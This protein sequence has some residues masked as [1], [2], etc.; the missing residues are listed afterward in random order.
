MA[1]AETAKDLPQWLPLADYVSA[2]P[3]STVLVFRDGALNRSNKL[4]AALRSKAEVWQFPLRKGP[5]LYSWIQ[6]RV[7]KSGGTISP[8]AVRLLADLVGGDL[9]AGNSEIEKL[10]LYASG[11][12]I[13]DNDVRLLVSHAQESNI[14]AMVDAIIARR[15]SAA[16]LLL[17]RLM[18][19]GAAPAYILTMITRQFRMLAQATELAGQELSQAELGRQ[20][21]TTS[22]FALRKT[23][24]QARGY[25]LAQLV[26]VYRRLLDADL[27]IKTG[28]WG[29][30]MALD[31]LITNLCSS[32]GR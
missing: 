21:G 5:A 20:L 17:H 22:D 7:T 29:G 32:R 31:L 14:F 13:A 6:E 27:S 28:R 2:T 19:H 3:P 1:S 12:M 23:L 16:I 24:D 25:S 18:D 10:L 4:L 9:W 8:S 30:E 15:P 26:G 11:R